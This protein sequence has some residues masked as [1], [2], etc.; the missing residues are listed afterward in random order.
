M[1]RQEKRKK[2]AVQLMIYFYVLLILLSLFTVASYTWFSLSRTPRVSDMYMFINSNT[3]LELSEDP[4]AEEWKLQLDFRDLATE[5]APLRPV[6]WSESNQQFIAAA[7]GPDGRQLPM[8][9][10]HK[11]TDE[12][13][14]N[15]NNAYGYYSKAA[16]FARSGQTETVFLSPAVEV[17]EGIDG[18]GT[19]VIGTPVWDGQS[20]VHNNGG[21][22]AECAIRIG[23]RI[24][25]VD[26]LGQPYGEP[27]TFFIYEPNSDMHID[28]SEGYVP[29]PSIDLMENLI[30]TDRLIL[31]TASTW[32]EAYPV[33]RGVVIHS[34]GEFTTETELFTI[35]PGE[36]KMIELY[37]WLEGQDVD[38]TN[39][40]QGAQIMASIQFSTKPDE[41]SG[42]IPIY[43]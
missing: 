13:N 3:G 24:T 32:S 25:P 42:L 4:L 37:C 41:Q 1:T 35:K 28:G 36:M 5:T 19:Y 17:D 8:S 2:R 31:Q 38:C 6:T 40:I 39:Q 14:A 12:Q 20:I 18:S 23:I 21:M 22:G 10:W 34:L 26:T 9:F 7:Y 11:L 43:D 15:R 33:E 30:S 16:F 29:T 27:A